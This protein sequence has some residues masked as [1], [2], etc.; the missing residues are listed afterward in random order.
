MGSEGVFS[1]KNGVKM[2]RNGGG[3]AERGE[4]DAAEGGVAI[5]GGGRSLQ[6]KC[7]ERV[8]G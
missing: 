6:S 7:F 5:G 2:S 4:I 1:Y 8:R 3:Q